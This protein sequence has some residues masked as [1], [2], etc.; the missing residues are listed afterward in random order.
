M[1]S[2]AVEHAL[3]ALPNIVRVQISL[4]TDQAIVEYSSYTEQDDTTGTTQQHGT[5][6]DAFFDTKQND[7]DTE[8]EH[9]NGSVSDNKNM[10]ETIVDTIESIGYTVEGDVR[11]LGTTTTTSSSTSTSATTS[12]TTT[13]QENGNNN[14][15]NGA[16]DD[17]DP[18]ARW[19]SLQDRQERKVRARRNAF[20]GSLLGTVPILTLTMILP[21]LPDR[22]SIPFLQ[23]HFEL[24][25]LGHN[26]TFQVQAVLLWILATPVQFIAGWEFYKMAWYGIASGRAG[27][28]VLVAMGTTAAYGYAT[29]G[30]FSQDDVAAHFFETAA[31]L[32][33]FVLAGKWMQAAAVRRTSQALT[34]LMQLQAKTAVKV[35]PVNST[36]TTDAATGTSALK[37]NPLVDPYHEAEVPIQEVQAGDVVKIIRGVS[38]PADGRVIAG[39]IS[40]D[41]S[42]VTGESLPILK[43]P[44]SSVLGGTICVEGN[45]S[46]GKDSVGA[47]F[48]QVTG[49]GSSTA[50]AQIVQLV[51]EAQTR[52][53][54]IQS[55][56]DQISA[57]FVPAVCVVSVLTFMTWYALCSA[58]VVPAHWYQD[59]SE[60]AA[61]FSLRFAIACLVISC[62]CAL[63]LAAPTATM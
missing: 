59:Q 43:T 53:V 51:Q 60:D 42:M 50:L 17:D 35:T 18:Q 8:H 23:H 38:I 56:A 31:V 34:Q 6:A 30:V 33:S 13:L 7:S 16:M 10:P 22:F 1:C 61:T 45:Q 54:P 15:N 52:S 2:Q 21:H 36:D 20:C 4:A 47:A 25:G 49:V 14:N 39:E 26:Y 32:I 62:P 28:D 41:E 3:M 24:W 37:F 44:G 57:V 5:D 29:A 46:D 55:F 27:M 40:V 12:A 63:G 58:N 9:P 48:V 11:V 19:Q